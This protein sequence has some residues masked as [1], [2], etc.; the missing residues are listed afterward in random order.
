MQCESE[1]CYPSIVDSHNVAAALQVYKD[2]ILIEHK[3]VCK[4]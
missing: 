2:E 3:M 4:L 1:I